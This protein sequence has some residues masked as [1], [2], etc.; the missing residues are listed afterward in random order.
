MSHPTSKRIGKNGRLAL[1]CVAILVGMTGMAYAAVPLYRAFCNATG[2]DGTVTRAKAAPTKVLDQT[3]VVRFD[4]NVRDMPWTFTPSQVSQTVKIGAQNLAFFKVTNNGDKAITGQA[5]FNVVPETAGIHFQ[6]LQCFCFSEQTIAAG[7]TVEFP[8]IY[9]VNPEY[10]TDP[11]TR[12]NPEITLS[13]T[14]F[15]VKDPQRQTA[16]ANTTSP[17]L[18]EPPRAGL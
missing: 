12:R 1:I 10:A 9:F 2:Y 7:Q 16:A 15:P 4:A 5:S 8:V 3:V 13:Y 6:K 11:E 14:F 17:G 18:G